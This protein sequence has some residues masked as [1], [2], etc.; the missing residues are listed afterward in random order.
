M[1]NLW[2]QGFPLKMRFDVTFH[3]YISFLRYTSC[4]TMFPC[5]QVSCLRESFLLT[6]CRVTLAVLLLPLVSDCYKIQRLCET[7]MDGLLWCTVVFY[8][9]LL[10]LLINSSKYSCLSLKQRSE[11]SRSAVCFSVCCEILKCYQSVVVSKPINSG[12]IP[13][14]ACKQPNRSFEVAVLTWARVH[15]SITS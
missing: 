6:S 7:K 8:V 4:R 9:A 1:T 10:R 15:A 13:C 2:H 14:V 3:K 5:K 11:E 12:G